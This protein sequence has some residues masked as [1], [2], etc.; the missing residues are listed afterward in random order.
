MPEG[1]LGSKG[2]NRI[3]DSQVADI[4][5]QTFD[6]CGFPPTPAFEVNATNNWWGSDTG[7]AMVIENG[8]ATVNVEPFLTKDP[9]DD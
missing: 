7:P 1:G 4:I 5:V 3:I 2:K 9:G 8:N 6:C